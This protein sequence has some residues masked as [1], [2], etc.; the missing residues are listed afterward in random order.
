MTTGVFSLAPGDYFKPG[1]HPN[2]EVYWIRSGMLWLGNPDT[3][4]ITQ[5]ERGDAL[6]I[7]AFQFH[8]GYNFGDET[9]EILL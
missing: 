8:F 6:L 3:G 9:V 7:P 5:L 2:P 1:N 4:Q